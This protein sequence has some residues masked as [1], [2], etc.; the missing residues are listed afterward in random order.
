M[1]EESKLPGC[2]ELFLKFFAR[3]YHPDDLKARV[4]EATRPD[5]ETRYKP[6][7]KASQ[8]HLVN[9]K[10][11]GV[12]LKQIAT[13]VASAQGDFPGYL[14]VSLPLSLEWVDVFD[15][16]YDEAEVL[17]VIGRSD[18]ADF[19]NDLV[20][21]C[22]EFGAVLG[23]T[24][25]AEEKSLEWLEDYPYWESALYD[26]RSGTRINVFHWAIKKFS[27]YGIDDGMYG[28]ASACLEMVRKGALLDRH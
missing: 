12:C 17:K 4:Y 20:V 15:R 10:Y 5:L 16:H 26:A 27:S 19:S 21:L 2:D 1:P 24:M 6:G 28:K 7:T 25:I 8:I 18:P 3:W 11:V 13:M 9:E 22:C 14:H 23:T